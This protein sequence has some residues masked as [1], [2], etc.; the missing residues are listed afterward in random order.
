MPKESKVAFTMIVDE[1]RCEMLQVMCSALMKD[2]LQFSIAHPD[3][4]E[5]VARSMKSFVGEFA[6]KQHEMGWCKSKECNHNKHER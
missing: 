6:E 3:R 4:V 1:D 2:F 5:S